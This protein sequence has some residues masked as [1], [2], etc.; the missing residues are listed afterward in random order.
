MRRRSVWRW[1]SLLAALTMAG[2]LSALVGEGGV[3]WVFSWLALSMPLLTIAAC[4]VRHLFSP[5]Q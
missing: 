5:L 4:V 2:L 1:P 3:W